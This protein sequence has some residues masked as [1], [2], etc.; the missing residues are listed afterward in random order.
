[1][2]RGGFIAREASQH[3]IA[4]GLTGRRPVTAHA[5]AQASVLLRPQGD[6]DT[7]QPIVPA[8]GPLRPEAKS[9][10]RERDVIHD[11]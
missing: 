2:N 10:K 3:V 9:A 8:V 1:M 6:L 4:Q 5:D 11:D 7:E